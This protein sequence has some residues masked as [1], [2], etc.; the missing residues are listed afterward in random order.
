MSSVEDDDDGFRNTNVS[1]C[2]RI[3]R[4]KARDIMSPRTELVAIEF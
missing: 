3:L 4:V 1:E 2:V